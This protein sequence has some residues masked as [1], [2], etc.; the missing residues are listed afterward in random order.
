MTLV[1]Q[2]AGGEN[3]LRLNV[4]PAH[5]EAA[6]G[7]TAWPIR[8]G[9][10]S[11]EIEM[12]RTYFRA[13]GNHTSLLLPGWLEQSISIPAPDAKG[14]AVISDPITLTR[15]TAGLRLARTPGGCDY[16]TAELVWKR[17]LDD[18]PTAT[19]PAEPL[20]RAL[21]TDSV[22]AWDGIPTG[23]YSL[24]LKGSE[25]RRVVD[26]VLDP[27]LAISSSARGGSGIVARALPPS[28]S[29]CY[30]TY[31]PTRELAGGSLAA[32]AS[33]YGVRLDIAKGSGE[34]MAAL[35]PVGEG[36][37]ITV[38]QLKPRPDTLWPLSNL[39]LREPA[40]V[41]FDC[42][43][44]FVDYHLTL[45][46]A[47]AMITLKGE[48]IPPEDTRSQAELFSRMKLLRQRQIEMAATNAGRFEPGS[49]GPDY[50]RLPFFSVL[51]TPE[52]FG[53]HL[54]DRSHHVHS[55]LDMGRSVIMSRGTS[56]NWEARLVRA[57]AEGGKAR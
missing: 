49:V 18:E 8:D 38:Q 44:F 31:V 50:Q 43:L 15:A 32:T 2:L 23:I 12:E 34:V 40:R 42:P 39:I 10:K 6:V 30:I 53:E 19:P 26:F 1:L 41:E 54:R 21:A 29:G 25:P 56:G 33:F 11:S 4:G 9:E 5:A 13:L 51:A 46:T 37:E 47:D 7:G 35:S 52:V 27:E 22:L 16:A 45:E 28:L 36:R 55:S 48:F 57:P 17:Q 24:V 3:G 14:R 20:R